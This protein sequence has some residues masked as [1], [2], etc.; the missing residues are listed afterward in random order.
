MKTDAK[1][2]FIMEK[3]GCEKEWKMKQKAQKL[4]KSKQKKQQLDQPQMQAQIS[5]HALKTP[6][7]AQASKSS[8]GSGLRKQRTVEN[9]KE[10][11][12][13]VAFGGIE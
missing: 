9:A 6:T 13:K 2:Q 12:K 7:K 4:S 8:G 5:S 11:M 10:L 1:V 3:L